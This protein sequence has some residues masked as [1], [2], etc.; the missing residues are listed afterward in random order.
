MPKVDDGFVKGVIRHTI[1]EKQE[2]I[3][4]ISYSQFTMFSKCPLSWKLRYIDKHRDDL[5]S[6]AL[7]FGTAFHETLQTYLYNIYEV[8]PGKA[9]KIDLHE[10]LRNNMAK[11]YTNLMEQTGGEIFTTQAQMEEHYADGIAILDFIRKKRNVYFSTKGMELIA[12][13]MPI[14]R[15]ATEDNENVYMYGFVDVILYDKDLNKYIIIDIKTSTNGWNKW[16]KADKTKTSQ[17]L[18]YKKYFA[19]QIGC[20]EKQIDV[21]YFIVRRKIPEE[22]MFPI[23]PV[24]EYSPASGK[25]SINKVMTDVNTFVRT[26]FNPDG[27]YNTDHNYL[28]VG[29]KGLKNCRWCPYANNEELCPK[30]ERIKE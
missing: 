19:E 18:I 17:L 1:Q 11:E 25:P 5:P 7:L 4:T 22:A 30:K 24:S 20:D 23:R 21:K 6:I 28:A 9:D 27:S 26:A 8:G 12:I 15:Q 3:K 14:Y 2:H 16:M 10:L 29:G 13:E